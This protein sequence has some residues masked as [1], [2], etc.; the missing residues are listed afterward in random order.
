MQKIYQIYTI[1]YEEVTSLQDEFVQIAY[2]FL[3]GK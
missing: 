2:S 1:L 3:T